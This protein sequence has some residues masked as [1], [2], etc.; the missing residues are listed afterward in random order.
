MYQ[1]CGISVFPMFVLSQSRKSAVS[2]KDVNMDT[3]YK[4]LVVDLGPRNLMQAFN[5]NV[6]NFLFVNKLFTTSVK[7]GGKG[8]NET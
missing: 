1:T 3:S 8:A 7:T 6:L 4:A 5:A 2:I